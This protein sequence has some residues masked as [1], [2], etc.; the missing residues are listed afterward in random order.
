MSWLLKAFGTLV[1]FATVLLILLK[2]SL[3]FIMTLKEV[4]PSLAFKILRS[5]IADDLVFACLFLCIAYIIR[6]VLFALARKIST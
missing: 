1:L 2:W 4:G 3:P 5:D 6:A